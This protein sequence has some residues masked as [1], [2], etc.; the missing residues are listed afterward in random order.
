MAKYQYTVEGTDYEV[1]I[2]EVEDNIAKVTVNGAAF[3]VELKQ[4]LKPTSRPIKQVTAPAPKPAAAP[5][6]AP[7]AAPAATPAAAPGAGAKIEAP[8][9]GTITDIKV[10]V[11][12]K[13][14]AGDTILVLEAMKM[15][16]NIE[17]EHD[18]EITSVMVKI[19]DS[20][21]E[22]SLLVTIA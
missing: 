3:E 7:A 16:N 9:P 6:Q 4:A 22:G 13:V 12:D 1:E 8:L 18:G 19:G 17:A 14:K 20:V 5:A 15:Q 11:G 21:M 2:L 10:K